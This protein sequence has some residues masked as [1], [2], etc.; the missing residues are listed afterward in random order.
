MINRPVVLQG[1]SSQTAFYRPFAGRP[2]LHRDKPDKAGLESP[3][4]NAAYPSPLLML[5]KIMYVAGLT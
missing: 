4:H 2:I 1:R 3:N 5:I